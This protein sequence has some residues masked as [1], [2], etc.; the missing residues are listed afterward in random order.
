MSA[1][2]IVVAPT[3]DEAC[4]K[5]RGGDLKHIHAFVDKLVTD[6]YRAGLHFEKLHEHTDDK[7]RSARVSREL[8]AIAYECSDVITLLWVDHHDR[9]YRW[10]RSKCV[11]CHPVTGRVLEVTD[12]EVI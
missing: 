9:A 8:R 1:S 5:F 11:T 7:M 6:P 10:A 4:E 12:A 3:F 2:E